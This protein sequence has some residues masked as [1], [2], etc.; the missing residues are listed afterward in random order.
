MYPPTILWPPCSLCSLLLQ[1]QGLPLGQDHPTLWSQQLSSLH[2]PA[3]PPSHSF[4]LTLSIPHSSAQPRRARCSCSQSPRLYS[5]PNSFGCSR[6]RC[7]TCC[8]LGSLVKLMYA[9][10]QAW[11]FYD[12]LTPRSFLP[13]AALFPAPT[14]Y[15]QHCL[16]VCCLLLVRLLFF[17]P[18][19]LAFSAD[20][21]SCQARMKPHL[22]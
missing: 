9:A 3:R 15:S 4:P 14:R 16:H 2:S 17:A 19:A 12:R 13:A 8:P 21:R 7:S 1:A 5:L 6:A 20:I 11:P 22:L 18:S 10:A